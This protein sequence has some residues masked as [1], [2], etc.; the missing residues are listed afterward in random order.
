MKI[1]ID[2]REQTPLI[3]TRYESER[4]T[5][6]SG[7]YSISGLTHKFAVERKSIDDLVQ[8]VT[9]ERERFERELHRLR[10]YDFKRLLII[11]TEDEIINRH[12]HSKVNPKSILHSV[13]AFE[14][15]YDIPIIWAKNA[16][17]GARYIEKW[18]YWYARE[19]QKQAEFING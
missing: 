13:N 9:R 11:G 17:I 7:D 19:I 8:S 12:Y 5:L 18:A 3:F 15:R 16:T 14:V 10:G 6:Q 4:G 1:I 2:T